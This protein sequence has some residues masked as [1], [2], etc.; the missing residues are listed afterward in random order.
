MQQ[1][2]KGTTAYKIFT[3]DGAKNRY[4]HA[5]MLHLSDLKNLREAL[6]FFAA[7][8]F[9]AKEGTALYNRISSGSY[10]DFTLY[11]EADKKYTADGVAAIIEDSAMRPVEGAKQL[12]VLSDF[13]KAS[14]LVQ[15]KL[16]KTLEETL[17][18]VYFILGVTTLAPVLD[19]VKSRV[20]LLEIPPFSADEI[21]AAL[22]RK[23]S[24]PL[25]RAAAERCNGILGDAEN[26]V[27]GGW[28]KEV[29]EAAEEICTTVNRE[30]ISAVA[31]K[32]GDIK[33]RQE[34]LSEMQNAYFSALTDGGKIAGLLSEHTLIYAIESINRALA[35]V[36]FNAFF[37][38]LL[39]DFMLRI[40]KEN[41][42]WQKLQ[43]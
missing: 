32:Y 23:G 15:N 10:P 33:Y 19:T 13:D 21:Y 39:Y 22:E 27:S 9:G 16:L 25:N 11:P 12:Y 34:L 14:A 37:Q 5:Y 40:A 41:D 17:E 43:V 30:D 29:R 20:K 26:M 18:G 38:G 28:F 42:K 6:L 24:N 36:R 2:I 7:E 3:T 31:Q 8:F 35:D 1:L 4:S